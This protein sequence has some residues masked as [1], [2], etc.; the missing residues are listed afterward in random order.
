MK[1]TRRQFVS[2]SSPNEL[3]FRHVTFVLY[4][5]K[6]RSIPGAYLLVVY[7]QFANLKSAQL[8]FL[9][10]ILHPR[11]SVTSVVSELSSTSGTL[12]F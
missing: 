5:F 4:C 10:E 1:G 11:Q 3:L 12:F 9:T 8:F 6:D 7:D 2:S